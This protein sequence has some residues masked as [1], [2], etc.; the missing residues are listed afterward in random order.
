[1]PSPIT[2]SSAVRTDTGVSISYASLSI[3]MVASVP[4][5]VRLTTTPIASTP[6]PT[7]TTVS[8]RSSVPL[9]KPLSSTFIRPSV[10]S[11]A[12]EP[13]SR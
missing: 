10:E 9:V 11:I 5:R 2:P 12:T 6:S 13:F 8:P 3:W 4:W 1:M 7:T